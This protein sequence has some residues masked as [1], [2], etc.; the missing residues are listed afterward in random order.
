MRYVLFIVFTLG[1]DTM[2]ELSTD[3]KIKNEVEVM[4]GLTVDEG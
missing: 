2:E 3:A 1:T 4:G